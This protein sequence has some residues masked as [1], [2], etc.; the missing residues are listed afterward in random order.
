[1]DKDIL[2]KTYERYECGVIES[3][4]IRTKND[5]IYYAGNFYQKQIESETIY[6]IDDLQIIDEK[7]VKFLYKSTQ[8]FFHGDVYKETQYMVYMPLSNIV[9]I[10]ELLAPTKT[11]RLKK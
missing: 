6:D 5:Q 11:E 10:Q 9:I 2:L 1:M 7:Y 3:F 4:K 8:W